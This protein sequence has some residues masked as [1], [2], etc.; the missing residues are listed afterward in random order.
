MREDANSA[1]RSD[2]GAGDGMLPDLV[3]CQTRQCK[4]MKNEQLVVM[5]VWCWRRRRKR[6]GRGEEEVES[7]K[8]GRDCLGRASALS[9]RCRQGGGGEEGTGGVGGDGV[10]WAVVA[11]AGSIAMPPLSLLVMSMSLYGRRGERSRQSK[12]CFQRRG[13]GSLLETRSG[14]DEAGCGSRYAVRGRRQ[15]RQTA[16]GCLVSLLLLLYSDVS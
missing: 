3:L 7:T 1:E 12:K 2:G 11:M 4:R 10:L 6:G 16:R 14:G 8:K 5:C 13:L 15:S 9:C